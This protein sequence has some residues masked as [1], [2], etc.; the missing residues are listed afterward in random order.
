MFNNTLESELYQYLTSGSLLNFTSTL[1]NHI[2]SIFCIDWFQCCYGHLVCLIC[3][4]N[5][6]LYIFSGSPM[7][8]LSPGTPPSDDF[9]LGS[10]M[11]PEVKYARY[12][13]C[14]SSLSK[15]F[16]F[17]LHEVTAVFLRLKNYILNSP[18]Q[19]DKILACLSVK[20]VVW[21]IS[22]MLL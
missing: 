22:T 18:V 20:C 14:F 13:N 15:Q 2:G 7:R 16:C 6:S 17:L 8:Q 11:S 12:W 9:D 21:L 4:F 3:L 5:L 19:S 1:L 10:S